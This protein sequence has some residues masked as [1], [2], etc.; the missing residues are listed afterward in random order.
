MFL[1]IKPL[2]GRQLGYRWRFDC[3]RHTSPGNSIGTV[4]VGGDVTFGADSVYEV[5][6]AGNGASDRIDATGKASLQGAP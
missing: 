4:T 2:Y 1:S 5:E 6:V 3:S